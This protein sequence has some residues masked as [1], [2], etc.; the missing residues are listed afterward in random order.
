MTVGLSSKTVPML[1]LSTLARWRVTP[2]LLAVPGLGQSLFPDFKQRDLLIHWD[3]MPGTS[4]AEMVRTTA[5]LDRRLRAVPGVRDFGAHIGRARQGAEI[6]GVN[7]AEVWISID[8]AVD[9]DRTVT[10]VRAVVNSY[11]GFYRDV[12][13]YLDERIEEV[14][15]GSRQSV[16]VRVYGQ[17]LSRMRSAATAVLGAVSAVPG[18]IDQHVDLSTDTP[19][20]QVQVEQ[21]EAFGP[22]LV[23]RGARERLAPIPMTS[24]ATGLALVPLVLDG[25]RPGHE[26]E[27]PIA[28]V[29][30]G[31]LLTSML[32][33]LFVVPSLYVRFGKRKESSR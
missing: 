18:T 9:Y 32:L 27:H 25:D 30:L 7:A 10:A 23:V 4:D 24:L 5:D 1:D 31:G 3:A 11:P 22:A 29:I 12:E 14:L 15:S 33:T 28:V 17:D 26:I 13:T 6:V 20:V 8:P 19:Q 16:I 21:A 2:R